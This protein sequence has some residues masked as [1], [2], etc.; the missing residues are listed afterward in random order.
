MYYKYNKYKNK[1]MQLKYLKNQS[2]GSNKCSI[3]TNDKIILGSGGSTSIIAITPDKR[4]YKIFTIFQIS[5]KLEIE[6][7]FEIK[8]KKLRI[9]TEIKIYEL[10]TKNII[11]KNISNHFVKYYGYN[12]CQGSITLF[13]SCP[14]SYIDFL[15]IP[16]NQ[17]TQLCTSY[18]KYYPE[19]VLI[20]KYKTIEIEYCDYSCIQFIEDISQTSIFEMEQYLDILF[21]QICHAI[22]SIR[23]VY[24]HFTHNDLFMRN[25]LGHRE[26]DNG[27]YYTYIYNKKTYLVPKKKFYPKINDFGY[28]N[29]NQKYKNLS[30]IDSDYKD[31]YNILYDIYAYILYLSR[32]NNNKIFFLK[33]YFSNYFD[34][35]IIDYFIDRSRSNMEID[36]NN[37]LDTEYLQTIGMVKPSNLLEN[38]F[39]PIFGKEYQNF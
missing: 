21:F 17:K 8:I 33:N 12:D 15:A 1:Y 16:D 39:Y 5:S 23:S 37:I 29:L 7:N 26:K 36:W 32:E 14:A 25:I 3:D 22:I 31:F 4:A 18:Y 35:E 27:N 2:G 28:S 24:P 19:N 38:Y 10:I 13:N 9:Q 34:V 11:N 6:K 20:D 30:L